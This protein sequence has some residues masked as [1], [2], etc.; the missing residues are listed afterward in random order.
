LAARC[1]NALAAIEISRGESGVEQ[2]AAGLMG[3][4]RLGRCWR[5][6]QHAQLR[7]ACNLDWYSRIARTIDARI[8]RDCPRLDM[9][10]FDEPR[11]MC[12]TT[13][14]HDDHRLVIIESGHMAFWCN[15]GMRH[16][17]APGDMLLVPAGRLHGSAVES[18]SCR[19]HQPI[20]PEA[21]VPSPE[22]SF[23]SAFRA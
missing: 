10:S 11:E 4:I 7:W 23:D 9:D 2:F 16:S 21:W 6:D 20:L 14:V 12:S 5:A 8:R 15:V 13:H 3:S 18:R 19:Y 17:M 1:A 22:S